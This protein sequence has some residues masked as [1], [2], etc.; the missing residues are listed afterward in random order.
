MTALKNNDNQLKA[1]KEK[2]EKK[3]TEQ[4][5]LTH[6]GQ[7]RKIQLEQQISELSSEKALTTSEI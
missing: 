3:L 4:C 5:Q 6:E 7:T 2:I 1:Q